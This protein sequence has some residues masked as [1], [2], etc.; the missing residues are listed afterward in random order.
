M[1]K[2]A[3]KLSSFTSRKVLDNTGP[4]T[5][6]DFRLERA[7]DISGERMF[8]I[9]REDLGMSGPSLQTTLKDGLG[10]RPKPG[11]GPVETIVIESVQTMTGN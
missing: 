11:K 1:G 8:E 7:R 10:L 5:G 3:E 2:L 6:F 4:R 9:V